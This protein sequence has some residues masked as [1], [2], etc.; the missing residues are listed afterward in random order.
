MVRILTVA[1]VISNT[2]NSVTLKEAGILARYEIS[3]R[4]GKIFRH[5]MPIVRVM[6][7]NTLT[8]YLRLG[9]LGYQNSVA[10]PCEGIG[11]IACTALVSKWNGKFKN[12]VGNVDEGFGKS[13]VKTNFYKFGIR[14]FNSPLIAL[15][16]FAAIALVYLFSVSLE[17]DLTVF[18]YQLK[19]NYV[20]SHPF[21]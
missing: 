19:T 7:Y 4:V 5:V 12:A 8:V 3:N 9:R 20:R 2:V 6:R 1:E 17:L 14:S 11:G 15:L 16:I 13:F 18:S 10:I 21:F